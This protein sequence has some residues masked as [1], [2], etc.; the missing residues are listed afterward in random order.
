MAVA[1]KTLPD[2]NHAGDSHA[3]LPAQ[4]IPRAD[5]PARR[6]W[7]RSST[8]PSANSGGGQNY[9]NRSG[10]MPNA[11][12][13]QEAGLGGIVGRDFAAEAAGISRA[14]P[15]GRKT[16]GEI[17]VCRRWRPSARRRTGSSGL[18][19]FPVQIMGALA[20]HRGYL[21][22][23]ATGEGKTLTAGLAAILAGWSKHPCHIVTVNDYLVERDAEWL[24]PLYHFC[25]VRVGFVTASTAARRNAPRITAATSPTS[26]ARNC[27]RIFCATGCILGRIA[28]SD[29]PVDPPDAHAAAGSRRTEWS[30]ADC[31]RRLWTRRTVF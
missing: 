23:M 26:P 2:L 8:A 3:G 13:A 18:R 1:S 16:G 27:W 6:A 12:V 7:T 10:A 9:W 20:L 29:A 19:P 14:I 5:A 4:R 24:E 17:L 28:R 30:C 15:P 25:G 21:A 11:I 31:T 22:E